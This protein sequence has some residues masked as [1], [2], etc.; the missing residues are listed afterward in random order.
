MSLPLVVGV[1][2]SPSSLQA[3]DWA[4][5]E[6]ALRRLALRCVCSYES[7][8]LREAAEQVAA[9]AVDRARR[10]SAVRATGVAVPG[11]PLEVLL[12]EGRNAVLLVVGDR[13]RGE[14]PGLLLGSVGL[15]AAARSDCPVV[16]VRGG[17][18]QRGGRFGCVVL[19]V[20]EGKEDSTATAF[21]FHEARIRGSALVAVHAWHPPPIGAA[22]R[23]LMYGSPVED[24]YDRAHEVL[25][26]A[27]REA[28]EEYPEV[29]VERRVT[30]G[31]AR[32]A[33]L[34]AAE[35][36]DLLVVGA[37]RGCGHL[38]LQLGLVAHCMLH[39]A[40][41]PVAVVPYF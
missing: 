35:K 13:G 11:D 34:E 18:L 23:S 16:V 24:S 8:E 20:R 41:C 15:Y 19:G 10:G 4:A 36:A 33:L 17:P 25:D 40:P 28:E 37:H 7:P 26:E 3:L 14:L 30:A 39:H 38:G 21:A 9:A 29:R 22:G 5:G 6:A 1:D 2:G 12:D 31:N 32:R 27:L